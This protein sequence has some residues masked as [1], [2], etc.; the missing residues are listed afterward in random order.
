M[1]FW[2]TLITRGESTVGSR[3]RLQKRRRSVVRECRVQITL[4]VTGSGLRALPGLARPIT[5]VRD[6]RARVSRR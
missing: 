5:L 6:R 4:R 1:G 2:A 3:R